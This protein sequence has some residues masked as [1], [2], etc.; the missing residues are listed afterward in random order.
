MK[1]K[2]ETVIEAIRLKEA[3]V[4][5]SAISKKLLAPASTINE[6]L[7]KAKQNNLTAENLRTLSEQDI[8]EILRPRSWFRQNVFLPDY[9]DLLVKA[10]A[11]KMTVQNVYSQYL[12]S[13]PEGCEPI[14]KA[15]FYREL[16][17][18]KQLA[19]KELQDVCL[20]NSFTPG[21]M[22]MIDYSGDGVCWK[23]KNDGSVQTAQIFVG[24]LCY[25]GLIFCTATNGQTRED[26]L[27]GITK[28]FH[29]FDGVT[30]ETWLDNSTP[31]VK[32]ADKYDPDLATEFSNFCD[33]YNTL[34]YAVEPGKSRHKALVENAVKQFQDRILNHLNKRSFFSIEE[35]NSAIE[36]LLAQ[37]NNAELTERPGSSRFSRYKAEER[38]LL[39]PLPL[40]AY[41]AHSKV[42]SRKVRPNNQLR[43]GNVRY[44]V[45]WGYVGK[46]LLVK[47]DTHTKEISF[48]D[49]S[50]G[51]ILTTTKIRNPSEGPEPQRKDLIPQDLKYLVENKEELL[52]RIRV[53]LGD[54]AWEVAK[55]LAKPNNS[56]AVRHL[57]GFLSMSKKYEKDF[58]DKVYGEL[59]K[60]AIIS[61]RGF[62]DALQKVE[63][64][65][66]VRY[67]KKRLKHGT[68]LDVIDCRSVR[69]AEYYKDRF[70]H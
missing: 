55:R 15:T 64:T 36:P 12:A 43:L 35:I 8:E 66:G 31:L 22:C 14:S 29:Y 25:S 69:G 10:S 34:G 24:V 56:M 3:G 11:P 20:L 52:D 18:T 9:E 28:M 50:D 39:R 13:V 4:T 2:T 30:E 54:K 48:I 47:V 63:Q 16:K 42:M 21:H 7:K 1:Y 5:T 51:E 53:Q 23:N 38:N 37:L 60:K 45:P 68:T 62:R 44:N 70:N 49:P 32:N 40:I 41:S 57:K 67:K 33:Y 59:L 46:E 65:E 27:A 58:M 26:W 19:S 61:F 17:R 6:W